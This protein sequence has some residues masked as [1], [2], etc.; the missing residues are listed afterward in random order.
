MKKTISS[1]LCIFISLSSLANVTYNKEGLALKPGELDDNPRTTFMDSLYSGKLAIDDLDYSKSRFIWVVYSDRVNNTYYSDFNFTEKLGELDFMEPLYIKEVR[2]SSVRVSALQR[3]TSTGGFDMDVDL[4]WIDLKFLVLNNKTLINEKGFTKKSMTLVSI[5][6]TF[7]Q[8]EIKS[9]KET[10][11]YDLYFDPDLK[12]RKGAENR[13]VIRYYLK[14]LQGSVLLS[15]IDNIERKGGLENKVSGWIQKNKT[16]EWDTRICLEPSTRPSAVNR[17]SNREIPLFR[18]KNHLNQFLQK[19]GD[20]IDN[21]IH[22]R[23]VLDGKRQHPG[24][25]RMPILN[26]DDNS[27]V[28]EVATF[29]SL[30][31]VDGQRYA[32]TNKAL[33][34]F[35]KKQKNFNVIFAVDATNSMDPYLLS[36][37]KSL[38]RIIDNKE[39]FNDDDINVRF[40]LIVYRD[41]PDGDEAL[42]VEP[43]TNDHQRIKIAIDQTEAKSIAVP[44]SEAVYHGIVEGLKKIN[45]PKDESNIV[46][47]VGDCGNHENDPKGYTIKDVVKTLND[48]KANLITFQVANGENIEYMKFQSDARRKLR[49]IGAQR[50]DDD[51]QDV[52][53]KLETAKHDLR[54]TNYLSVLRGGDDV[55]HLHVFGRYTYASEGETMDPV[56]LEENIRDA[57]TAYISAVRSKISEYESIQNR[58]I[59]K[60][61]DFQGKQI[62]E[63]SLR[64]LCEDLHETD[65]NIELDECIEIFSNFGDISLRA[66]LSMKN[67]GETLPAFDYVV[68]LSQ[69]ELSQLAESYN[70]LSDQT[71]RYSEKIQKLYEAL[72]DQTLAK[73]G[74]MISS[75]MEERVKQMTLNQI[76]QKLFNLPFDGNN[77]YGSLGSTKLESILTLKDNNR[78]YLEAFI[79]N[80][81][82]NMRFNPSR[83]SNH[84]FD[85][86]GTRFYW[87]P[88][89]ELPGNA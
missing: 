19:G 20:A 22:P 24:Q 11:E 7:S 16:T 86:N 4:G 80:N 71:A 30:N 1:L 67:Y 82:D 12:K 23:I 37:G 87:I 5:S 48:Y 57:T 25:M 56:L 15:T 36:V 51:L 49:Q 47:L 6:E 76:W 81:F 58:G 41:Y 85:L 18:N 69:T 78:K 44:R 73:T 35:K 34:S 55:S 17:Y 65:P 74:D 60:A 26:Y 9:L 72:L 64:R 53:V 52:K 42:V 28:Y 61:T 40:G 89:D 50:V 13:F 33:E 29:L 63:Y 83:F 66:Y 59:R 88:L 27:D 21:S 31:Q 39:G 70:R 32:I 2:G 38:Q 68:F 45:P 75:S 10:N 62:D 43:L 14:E 46:V 77:V 8:R 3:P 79:R 84:H 54:N